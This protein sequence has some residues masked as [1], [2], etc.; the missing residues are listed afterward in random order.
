[1]SKVRNDLFSIGDLIVDDLVETD[2]NNS[3]DIIVEHYCHI[4]R[5]KDSRYA[6][7]VLL[8]FLT[9]DT[10]LLDINDIKDWLREQ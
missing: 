4:L 5:L 8:D 10:Y 7:S 6:T 1:M 9:Y 3:L 2:I